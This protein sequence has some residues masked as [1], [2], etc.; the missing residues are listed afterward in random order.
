MLVM[1]ACGKDLREHLVQNIQYL[2]FGPSLKLTFIDE[3]GT[4]GHFGMAMNVLRQVIYS[5]LCV[6]PSINSVSRTASTNCFIS[7]GSKAKMWSGP[8]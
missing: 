1:E 3:I 4:L 8:G 2:K 5:S 6:F 7:H